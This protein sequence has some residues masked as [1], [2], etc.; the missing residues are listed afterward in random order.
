M[1]TA[2]IIPTY[3]EEKN[4]KNLVENIFKSLSGYEFS[5]IFVDDSSSDAT[6]LE[7]NKL[8]E[9]FGNIYLYSRVSKLGLASAYIEGFKYAKS[10]GF[11]CVI[12]MDADLS[13]NPIY[14]KEMFDKLGSC[15]LVIGSR[16]VRGGATPDWGILRKI[17]SRGGSIYSKIILS[18]PIN[19]L[20][21]GF[22]G[23][24]IELLDRINLD[25]IISVGYC[26]QI[27]MKYK[28]FKNGAKIQEFPIVFKDR[29]LGKSKMSKA[30]FVEALLNVIKLRFLVK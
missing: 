1:K 2:I 12:Q 28:A 6:V 30:I 15:D 13:H 16:Y 3:N 4:I 26:F 5:I 9:K 14:L 22:N 7:I 23:W 27:E 10:L 24:H 19:D 8:K 29:T 25:K 17:I 20:T 18:C 11:D 21:G